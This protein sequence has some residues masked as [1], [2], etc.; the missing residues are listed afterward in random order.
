MLQTTHLTHPAV[1]YKQF[2]T[3]CKQAI[4]NIRKQS[5]LTKLKLSTISATT[6]DSFHSN[7]TATVHRMMKHDSPTELTS[8]V[9]AAGQLITDPTQMK[10]VLHNGFASVF[11]LPPP[12]TAADV[13]DQKMTSPYE[14]VTAATTTPLGAPG[15]YEMVYQRRRDTIQDDWYSTLMDAVSES[16]VRDVCSSCPYYAA[17]GHDGVS[18]GV[19]R[20]LA[21][22]SE[23]VCQVLALWIFFSTCSLLSQIT[24]SLMQ[25]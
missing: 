10:Q 5:K 21:E 2:V 14:M 8:V 15:W 20:V 4:C 1:H 19:W 9:D 17:P 3:D 24:N 25:S 12:T 6:A 11:D 7:T 22:R 13:V 16:E 23:V 18:A